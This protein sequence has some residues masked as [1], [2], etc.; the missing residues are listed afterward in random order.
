MKTRNQIEKEIQVLQSRMSRFTS[1]QF[2]STVVDLIIK[3]EL[4]QAE[5]ESLPDPVPAT[6]TLRL[7]TPRRAWRAWVA[8]ISPEIDVKHG[9]FTKE[10][11]PPVDRQFNKKGETSATFRLT[12]VMGAIY[13][14]SD[15][16]YWTWE[17]QEGD[18]KVISYQEVKYIFSKMA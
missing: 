5:L 11:L 6:R 17:N 4:L 2:K 7:E 16:D 9:G 12:V 3:I 10:F 18:I 13:Q 1:N 14:D 15:G 8:Q